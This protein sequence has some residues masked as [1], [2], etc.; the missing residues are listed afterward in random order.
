MPAILSLKPCLVYGISK[1]LPLKGFPQGSPVIKMASN[2]FVKVE[3]KNKNEVREFYVIQ[4]DGFLKPHPK[5]K[6]TITNTH[7]DNPT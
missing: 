7:E 1:F 5:A 2:D 6:I 4:E 3:I